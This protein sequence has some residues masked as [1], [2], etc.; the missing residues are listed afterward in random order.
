MSDRV[1]FFF[2][3]GTLAHDDL[4]LALAEGVQGILEPARERTPA[5]VVGGGDVFGVWDHRHP[6]RASW[7]SKVVVVPVAGIERVVGAAEMGL[8]AHDVT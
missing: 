6:G 7:N 1:F 3:A 4:A 2:A 5:V 8:H